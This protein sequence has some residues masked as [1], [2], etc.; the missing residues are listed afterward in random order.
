LHGK[1]FFLRRNYFYR[2]QFQTSQTQTKPMKPKNKII[3]GIS[4]VCLAAGV[5]IA[6]QGD[7]PRGP[8][9][10]GEDG[11]GAGRMADFLKKADANADGKISKE[12]F[13]S[14][15]TKEAEERFSMIDVNGDG[16]AD[17]AE[18]NQGGQRM[19]ES[20]G[21]G[22]PEGEGQGM[23]RPGGEGGEGGFRRPPS[24]E[25]GPPEGGPGGGRPQGGPP[26]GPGGDRPQGGPGGGMRGG[27]GGTMGI[28]SDEMFAKMDKN[29]DGSIDL[30]EYTEPQTSE[31]EGRFKR[32]DENGD[33][34]VSKDEMKSGIEKM[35]SMMM[36]GGGQGGPGGARGGQNGPGGQGG[37]RRPPSDGDGG[38]GRP[39]PESEGEAPKKEGGV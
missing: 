12:E 6:Q 11:G 2:G 28:N 10:P 31:I 33:G 38:A 13:V 18:I 7:R 17:T 37:F 36:Q 29:G 30:A 20:T 14:A 5:A 1:V 9:G 32:M 35:R 8:G 3:F 39:R 19:R 4:I 26:G 34:K 25:G 16:S 15:S 27:P 24:G 21:G 22:R 23:R